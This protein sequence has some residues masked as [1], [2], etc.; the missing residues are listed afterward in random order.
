MRPRY[1]RQPWLYDARDLAPQGDPETVVFMP[2]HE[3]IEGLHIRGL[4]VDVM[5]GVRVT[6]TGVPLSCAV[7]NEI[8]LDVAP[9]SN[10]RRA[11]DEL[12]GA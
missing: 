1:P 10:P 3:Q 12:D 6:S 11:T 8:A 7:T 4:E 5:L 2:H 9:Q